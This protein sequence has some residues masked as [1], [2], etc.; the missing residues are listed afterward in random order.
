MLQDLER[1]R[2]TEIGFINGH[3]VD[4]GRKLG[5][6]TPFNNEVLEIIISLESGRMKPSFA[7]LRAFQIL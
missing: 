2:K 1:N 5:I 4:I 6:P 7:A 3:V